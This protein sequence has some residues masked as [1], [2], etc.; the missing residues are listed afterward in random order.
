MSLTS[1]GI[2]LKKREGCASVDVVTE[3]D[4]VEWIMKDVC[5]SADIK[6][7]QCSVFILMEYE[8]SM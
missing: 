1:V 6:W 7:N 3:Q 5:F 8:G 4:I 2:R